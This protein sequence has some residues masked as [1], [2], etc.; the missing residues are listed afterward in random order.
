MLVVVGWNHGQGG[1]A[2]LLPAEPPVVPGDE[3]LTRGTRRRAQRTSKHRPH[4]E[5]CFEAPSSSSSLQRP[6]VHT[7]CLGEL[8]EGQQLLLSPVMGNRHPS[9]LKD[10]GGDPASPTVPGP[11]CLERHCQERGEFALFQADVE[12]QLAN[13][14]HADDT[15]PSTTL[16][17]QR[18]PAFLADDQR[19]LVM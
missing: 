14:A 2:C 4:A 15:M 18:P 5:M 3:L 6:E 17:V 19:C 13:L 8:V 1:R 9:A 7:E 11:Q 12:S 10:D 16:L